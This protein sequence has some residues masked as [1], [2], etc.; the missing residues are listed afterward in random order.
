LIVRT[1]VG[2]GFVDR[3]VQNHKLAVSP[4]VDTAAIEKLAL[5]KIKKNAKK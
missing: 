3:A 5:A 4:G 1:P 2:K